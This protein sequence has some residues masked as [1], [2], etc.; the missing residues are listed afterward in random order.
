VAI[1]A[2]TDTV[3]F[4]TEVRLWFE[5]TDRYFLKATPQA[6]EWLKWVI[7]LVALQVAVNKTNDAMAKY[8]VGLL[9]IYIFL[10]FNAF[11]YKL[12]FHELPLIKSEEIR[13]TISIII[14]GTLAYAMYYSF[15]H[16][17]TILV[18]STSVK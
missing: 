5:E 14:S 13:R 12:K 17:A 9:Y 1:L 10:Y 18:A 4:R 2:V 15:T 8:I 11:F 6:F 7:I 16:L 3:N